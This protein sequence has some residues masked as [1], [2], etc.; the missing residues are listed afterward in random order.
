MKKKAENVQESVPI[1]KVK[2]TSGRAA[3]VVDNK[4]NRTRAA[5][6][7][8]IERTWPDLCVGRE[9]VGCAPDVERQRLQFGILV[10]GDGEEAGVKIQSTARRRL[11]FLERICR[12]RHKRS[13][14]GESVSALHSPEAMRMRVVP[15]SI[16][17]AVDDRTVVPS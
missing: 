9:V 7:G 12:Y 3:K 5:T 16:I 14:S 13:A 15:V 4:V 11:V 2:A 6:D 1:D 17:P 8:S 10:V